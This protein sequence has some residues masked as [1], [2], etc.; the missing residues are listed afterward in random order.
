MAAAAIFKNQ[1]IATSRPRFEVKLKRE[2]ELL[3]YGSVLFHSAGT[4]FV[5]LCDTIYL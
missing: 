2:V 1:K 3:H 5:D 4:G